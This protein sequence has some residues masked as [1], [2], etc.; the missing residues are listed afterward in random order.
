MAI[1]IAN[2]KPYTIQIAFADQ[3]GTDIAPPAGGSVV[4][5]NPAY[6]ATTLGADGKTV[7]LTPAAHAVTSVTVTYTGAVPAFS[8][9]VNIGD[10][11]PASGRF[12]E[13]TLTPVPSA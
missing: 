1:D 9:V 8:E 7:T 3:G 6:L 4:S 10:P 12:V 5:S 2:N 13:S 11:V